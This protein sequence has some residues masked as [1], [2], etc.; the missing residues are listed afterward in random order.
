MTSQLEIGVLRTGEKKFFDSF[1]ITKSGYNFST[2]RS[3]PEHNQTELK[4]NWIKFDPVH[5]VCSHRIRSLSL[6]QDNRIHLI[7]HLNG[8][9]VLIGEHIDLF[10]GHD[11]AKRIGKLKVNREFSG[12]TQVQLVEGTDNFF[13]FDQSRLFYVVLGKLDV[14]CDQ[15]ESYV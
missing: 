2:T 6:K 10:S 4:V 3:V 7:T 5:N 13:L 1:S 15:T 8:H 14:D 11:Y 12:A 9:L